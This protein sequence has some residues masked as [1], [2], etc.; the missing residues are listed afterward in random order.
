M[1]IKE[2][3]RSQQEAKVT[4]TN[5]KNAY[6][7][8]TRTLPWE[9]PCVRIKAN[10]SKSVHVMFTTKRETC[11]PVHINNMQIPQENHLDHRL[12][13][14]THTFLLNV[15]SLDRLLFTKMYWSLGRKSKLSTNNKLLIYK[16]SD[17]SGH[18][19]FNSG[20]QHPIQTSKF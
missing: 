11:P 14:H 17:P 12:T 6:L 10:E 2:R 5:L 1:S 8:S 15:N 13:W 20:V 3:K 19:A 9:T 18:M 4:E 16:Y 7:V